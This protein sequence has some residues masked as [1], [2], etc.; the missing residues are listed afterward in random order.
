MVYLDRPDSLAIQVADRLRKRLR[1][2]YSTGGQ[3]PSEPK[4]ASAFGV[5]RGTVRQALTILEREGIIFRRQGSGTYANKYVL[6]IQ[7]RAEKAHEFSDLL[8]LAGFTPGIELIAVET[9]PLPEDIA[10][11]M[12]QPVTQALMVHKLFLAD[13][14]PAIYCLDVIPEALICNAYED[15]ELNQ[16]IFDFL[17]KHCRQSVTQVLAEIIPAAADTTLAERLNITPGQSLLRFDEVGFNQANQ[18]I[19]FS[20]VYYN[21]RFIR[22]SILR[23]KV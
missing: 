7:A 1:S 21:D 20:R 10:A 3:L 2:E 19:L 16:P 23:K 18:P 14:S 12:D 13:G 17:E 9:Q 6:R 4:L 22:F 8:G 5:S 11:R 15:G